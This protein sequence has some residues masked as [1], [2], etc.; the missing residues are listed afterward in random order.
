LQRALYQHW[1]LNGRPFAAP[2]IRPLDAWL[3]AVAPVRRPDPLARLLQV[4]AAVDSV[5]PKGSERRSP[6]ERLAMAAGLMQVLDAVTLSGELSGLRDP[7]WLAR[8][9]QAFGSPSPLE[10]LA[11]FRRGIARQSSPI[12]RTPAQQR[13]HP[14]QCV[15]VSPGDNPREHLPRER[16]ERIHVCG[17]RRGPRRSGAAPL[18][19]SADDAY[20]AGSAHTIS[21]I[22]PTRCINTHEVFT[23]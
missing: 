13:D 10:H 19:A 17:R 22:L 6:T 11:H 3:D 18:G 23:F 4:L 16:P 15:A 5:M 2:P 9:T 14:G 8:A 20:I 7:D 1:G 12:Q 21:P